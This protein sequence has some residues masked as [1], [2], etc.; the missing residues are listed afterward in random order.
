MGITRIKILAVLGA[1][2]IGFS[3]CGESDAQDDD[4][5]N[6]EPIVNL[7]AIILG[8]PPE[9]GMEDIYRELDNLTI[10]ELN[11]TLRFEY[12][13]WGDERKQL[14]IAA[15][16]GEY[17]FIPEGVFS[18]YRVLV[19]KNAFLNLNQYLYL[20]P[21]LVEHYE[22]YL[23]NALENCEINGGLYGIPQFTIGIQNADEGFFYREDLRKEWGLDAVTDLETMEAYLYRAKEE[24]AYK[25]KPLITD[26]RIWTSLWLLLTEGNYL[27]IDSMQETPF[28]VVRAEEPDVVLSRME[29]PEFKEVIRYIRKWQEDGILES[30]MLALSDNEG[31]RG[32]SLLLANQKPCETNAPFWSVTSKFIPS[33]YIEHPEW[34]FG[35]FSYS[36]NNTY[37]FESSLADA[38]VISISSKTKAPETAIKLLAKI[39]TDHR[40]YD[41]LKYGVEG[42]HYQL[43]EGKVDYSNA[44]DNRFG[45]T[46]ISDV[47]LAYDDLPINTTWY[48]NVE[49]PYTD[50]KLEIG[51][52]AV[53]D[54]LDDF[55][56]DVSNLDQVLSDMEQVR[57]TS[58]QP[59]LCGYQEDYEQALEEAN[60]ALYEA[61]FQEY[62]DEIQR[63]ISKNSTP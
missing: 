48:E 9:E 58:F 37:W 18:D 39:H 35:F 40:Y 8:E 63:Q 4:T 44:G 45:W 10:P 47:L 32:K 56:L 34:E 42:I 38:S 41:L 28:V 29:T 5:V 21:E 14:N 12:I 62:L 20:V 25:D 16:S 15:A 33:L 54:P 22:S 1:L 51:R 27:E 7:K 59:I 53:R 6:N 36:R 24:E 46:P 60:E 3:G 23:D 19:S 43:V 31:E 30:N 13:P 57:I 50:W 26:N 55:S 17:D 61:G 49:K 11:C 2:A 52:V